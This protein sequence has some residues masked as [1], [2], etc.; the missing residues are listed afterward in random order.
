M[1]ML[2]IILG[3]TANFMEFVGFD[4]PISTVVLPELL[5]SIAADIPAV[6]FPTRPW[7]TPYSSR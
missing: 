2:W 5:G 3:H 1:C 7:A 6:C 4:E